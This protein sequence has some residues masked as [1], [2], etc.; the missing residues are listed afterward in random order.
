MT[1][2]HFLSCGAAATALVAGVAG[3]ANAAVINLVD[4][5]GVAGSPAAEGFN[6]A[7]AYWGS[8]RTNNVTVN[9]GVGFAPLPTNVIGSTQSN[10]Q[11]FSVQDWENDVGA[12]K[13]GSFI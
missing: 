2:R 9:L 6:I 11:N 10:L 13:S 3:S 7:A 5:G 4:L 8:G 1:F 12:T